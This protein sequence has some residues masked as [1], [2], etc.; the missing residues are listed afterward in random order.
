MDKS[1]AKYVGWSNII[2]LLMLAGVLSFIEICQ[3]NYLNEGWNRITASFRKSP[4]L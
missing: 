1:G 2:L 4:N 3:V